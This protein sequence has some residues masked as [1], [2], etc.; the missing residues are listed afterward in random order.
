[1]AKFESEFG[2]DDCVY[3]VIWDDDLCYYVVTEATI[4]SVEF[5]KYGGVTY[6]LDLGDGDDYRRISTQDTDERVFADHNEAWDH[7]NYLRGCV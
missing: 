4:D 5:G 1:M 2:I 6:T 7:C 3:A